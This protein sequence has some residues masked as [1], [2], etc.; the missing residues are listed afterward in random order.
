VIIIPIGL[1]ISLIEAL[2]SF[3]T[4]ESRAKREYNA[5]NDN[6]EVRSYDQAIAGYSEAVRLKP[7]FWEAHNNRV[8][9]YQAKGDYEA[10]IADFD[11]AFRLM[12]LSSE[13][14][15]NRGLA[16]RAIGAYDEAIADFNKAIEWDINSL[17][18]AYYDNRGV[19][20][21]YKEE[22]DQAIAD[23]NADVR[24]IVRHRLDLPPESAPDEA[25]TVDQRLDERLAEFMFEEELPLIYTHRGLAYLSKED[26]DKALSDFDRAI[27]LRPTLALAFYL[28]GVTYRTAGNY[29][30][31]VNDF[32]QVID[33]GNDPGLQSEAEKQLLEL[34]VNP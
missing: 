5:G 12:P 11:Q 7:E 13:V 15:N 33:L 22:Y 9:G 1:F 6:Y 20:Y 24:A 32:R 17:H 28:R 30:R 27:K 18:P 23:F 3:V 4:P 34:G 25:D 21:W 29:D 2:V 31:A 10:A 8:L 14:L 26:V 19:A 16:Y